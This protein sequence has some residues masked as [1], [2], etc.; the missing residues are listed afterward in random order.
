MPNGFDSVHFLK[1]SNKAKCKGL[2]LS[3][4]YLLAACKKYHY[5]ARDYLRNEMKKR[6]ANRLSWDDSHKEAKRLTQ[7]KE[8]PI[9]KALLTTANELGEV[10]LQFRTVTDSHD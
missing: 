2:I 10:R 7:C 6:S 8:V 5:S 3:S 4:P 9:F 1:F